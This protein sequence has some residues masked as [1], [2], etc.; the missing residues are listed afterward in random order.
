MASFFDSIAERYPVFNGLLARLRASTI[1][2]VLQN[3]ASECGVACLAMVLGYHGRMSS[4]DEVRSRLPIA[5]GSGTSAH[6]LLT[7]AETF[8]LRGRAVAIDLADLRQLPT[9]A[10]LHWN[11]QHYVV[12]ERADDD[13]VH[14]VNPAM[15]RHTVDW[16]EADRAFSGVAI[17]L[18]P[19]DAFTR[20][21]APPSALTRLLLDVLREPAWRRVMLM[22]VTLQVLAFSLPALTTLAIDR[23]IPQRDDRL[24]VLSGLVVLVV[25]LLF[26]LAAAVRSR[27][28]ALVLMRTSLKL[29]IDFIERL[30]MAQMQFVYDRQAGDI[31][32]MNSGLDSVLQAVTGGALTAMVDVVMAVLFVTVLLVVQP[33]MGLVVLAIFVSYLAVAVWSTQRLAKLAAAEL[34]ASRRLA[35]ES[36]E[37]V[38]GFETIK[39]LGL[40]GKR[41]MGSMNGLAEMAQVQARADVLRAWTDSVLSVLR[42]TAP[43]A[44]LLVGMSR[45][46]AGTTSVGQLLA[47]LALGGAALAPLGSITGTLAALPRVHAYLERI[48]DVFTAPREQDPD[49]RRATPP[50]TGA[51]AL[52]QVTFR[53]SSVLPIVLRGV[54]LEVKAGEFVA[55]VGR[56]GSGKSTLAGVILGLLTPESGQV[57]FDGED[58]RHLELVSLR[59]QIGY[60]PQRP[61]LFGQSV[62]D[63]VTV[64]DP[65]ITMDRVV[66]AAKLAAIHDEIQALPLGYETMLSAFSVFSGGQRQR[67]ALA[68]ALVRRP[69][70][71]LLD[72]A[73]SAVDAITERKIDEVV[74]QLG[75]TRIAIAH[76]LSTIERA[77]RIVVMNDGQIEAVGT[78]AELLATSPTFK[79]LYQQKTEAPA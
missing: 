8:A 56:S 25:T 53:Y 77:N 51:L 47:L 57:E 46:M 74:R 38:F 18:E 3:Q 9:A 27:L 55:I 11:M 54:D 13:G 29:R 58:L 69:R 45:V 35:S 22:A 21:G 64:G 36:T 37:T 75:C 39:S 71:L 70:V 73:T 59:Q 40:E 30:L 43:L 24:F 6:H 49:K 1:P 78:L 34:Y 10:V 44:L 2:L 31:A 7:A 32:F 50:L 63:N 52:R 41:I 26:L 19:N 15:G 65:T 33:S 28:V 62:R 42:F 79:A 20:K 67:L 17:L 61:Y 60:V 14:L 12:L 72:E 16:K 4:L 5:P 76:R 23:I 68:R 48:Q 66:E